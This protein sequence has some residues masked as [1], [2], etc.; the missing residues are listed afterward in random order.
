[1]RWVVCV[2]GVLVVAGQL[3]AA[4]YWYVGTGVR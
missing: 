2:L 4:W 3:F 1:M